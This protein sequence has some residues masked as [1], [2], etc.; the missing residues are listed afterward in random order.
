MQAEVSRVLLDDKKTFTICQYDDGP[1]ADLGAGK[2]FLSSRMAQAG[3]DIPLLSNAHPAPGTV[4]KKYLASFVGNFSSHPVRQKMADALKGAGG[5]FMFDSHKK[6]N[7][8]SGKLLQLFIMIFFS[9]R[10]NFFVRKTREAYVA[11][12][13]RGYGGSSF[14]FFEAMQLGVVPFL[15]GDMDTRPFKDVIKWDNISFYTNDTGRVMDM[16]NAVDKK[17]LLAMGQEAK[18]VYEEKLAYQK[19]CPLVIEKLKNHGIT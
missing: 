5:I 16:I 2:V 1:M 6:R 12:C 18:K 10:A 14:R 13:P 7:R 4:N 15:I 17:T 8:V 9:D 11:L 3:M 19:W